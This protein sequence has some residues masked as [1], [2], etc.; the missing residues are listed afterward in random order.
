MRDDAVPDTGPEAVLDAA[1]TAARD[2]FGD[3]LLAA[4]TLGSLA[5]GGF[6]PLVSDVDLALVLGSVDHGTASRVH[7]V[8][9]R[10]R[11]RVPGTFAERLSVFWATPKVVRDGGGDRLP[12]RLPAVDRLDLLDSGIARLAGAD[13][14]AGATRPDRATL[15][16]EAARF[17]VER[18][19]GEWLAG[20]AD[21]AELLRGGPRPVT[22]TVLFPVRFL[23]TL[24]T[25]EIGRNEIAADAYDGP[26]RPLVEAA[27]RW[28]TDG[29]GDRAAVQDLL[30]THLAG[31]Y[32]EF[33]YAYLQV[34]PGDAPQR[35]GLGALR[36]AVRVL[37]QGR[38]RRV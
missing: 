13:V 24:R 5:H 10:V 12:Y 38:R 17:A 26:H 18:F 31:L 9:S 21:P 1:C 28:R 19:D 11:H 8:A 36:D 32:G 2:E 34:L 35:A 20:I 14:G 33:V 16:A 29:L 15:V 27:L 3:D 30:V 23:H 37:G 25:G 7:D 6:A 4:Y 22:K